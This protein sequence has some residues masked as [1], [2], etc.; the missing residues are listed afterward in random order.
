[1]ITR[2]KRIYRKLI[3]SSRL[4][5]YERILKTAID[6]GYR[7]MCLKEWI[8][9]GYPQE[10]ILLLRHDVDI[11]AKGARRMS[12]I[13]RHLH[14]RAT[15]YFR[16]ITMRP[17]LMKCLLADGFEVGLHYETLATCIRKSGLTSKEQ[18]S[19]EILETCKKELSK[20]ISDFRKNIGELHSLCSH[21]SKWNRK[22]EVPNHILLDE[23][24]KKDNAILFEAYDS[25]LRERI[26]TYISDSSLYNKHVWRYGKSPIQA[27]E[28]RDRVILLL[29]HPEHWNYD[30]R[31]NVKKLW[32]EFKDRN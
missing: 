17:R 22:L 29:T 31:S 19:G 10:K 20:E 7:V 6:N 4:E 21:G 15:Y 14:V 13:E 1:M 28:E 3:Q 32:V 9:S 24:F 18:L 11:D 23:K 25:E 16:H 27:I 5:E 12:E 2:L 8:Q 26:S 30:F